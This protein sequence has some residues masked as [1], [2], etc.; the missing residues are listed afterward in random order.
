MPMPIE[1]RPAVVTDIPAMV[2][3]AMRTFIEGARH[4][5]VAMRLFADSFR[6]HSGWQWVAVAEGRVVGFAACKYNT[7]AKKAGIFLIGVDPSVKGGGIGG[8]LLA[9]FEEKCRETK[10]PLIRIGTPY[11]KT[12]YEKYGYICAET[13]EKY[14]LDLL[15]KPEPDL[16]SAKLEPLTLSDIDA[17]LPL[18]QAERQLEFLSRF[19]GQIGLGSAYKLLEAGTPRL[20]FGLGTKSQDSLEIPSAIP[21]LMALDFYYF[22]GKEDDTLLLNASIKAAMLAGARR[23]GL[24]PGSRCSLKENLLAA[25]FTLSAHPAYW[26]MYDMEKRI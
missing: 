21:E 15:G 4:P 6:N 23:F 20:V 1:Y 7:T 19:Y 13:A 25:G 26:T 11:A 9:C 24:E 2:H 3:L 16:G 14:L 10:V 18:I 5:A 8:K 12:F 17:L 22:L